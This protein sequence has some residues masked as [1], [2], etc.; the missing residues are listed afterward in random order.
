MC[1]FK[2]GQ[3]R[4]LGDVGVVHAPETLGPLPFAFPALGI[5]GRIFDFHI[6]SLVDQLHALDHMKLV[7]ERD[8]SIQPVVIVHEV[9]GIHYQGIV[10]PMP[11]G[12]AVEA[13]HHDIRIGMRPPVQ[14]DDTDAVHEAADHVD[15]GGQLDHGDGPHARHDYGKS[16]GPAIADIVLVDLAGGG[17]FERGVVLGLGRGSELKAHG[18]RKP[19]VVVLPA[20]VL[21]GSREVERRLGPALGD[22]RRSQRA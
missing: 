6:G 13:G 9:A 7:R 16:G 12:F 11:D 17:R 3:A 4:C 15:R 18:R 10:F 1:A 8:S 22:I 21:P 14:V 19:E 2:I 5:G 20:A